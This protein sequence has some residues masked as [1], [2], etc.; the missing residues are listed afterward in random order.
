MLGSIIS[1]IG[2]IAGGIFNANKQEKFAK[3]ALQWKAADAEKAGISKI[4][5]MGAPTHSFSPVNVG[6]DPNLGSSIDKAMGQGGPQSTTTGKMAGASTAITAA[7]LD[8]LRLDNDIKRAELASKLAIAGQPGAGGVLDRDVTSGPTGVQLERKLP[9]SSPIAPHSS[10]GVAPEV[11][12]YR[13]SRGLAPAPPQNLAEVHENNAI[14]RWQWMYRN[15]LL[16]FMGSQH[17]A[18]GP[19]RPGYEWQFNPASGEYIEAPLNPFHREYL[20]YWA[21]KSRQERSR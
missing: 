7:Q 20:R 13:T 2:N 16:P 12:L 1:T 3:S 4:F 10:Y 8:G 5:A 15:Q 17:H 9:P 6:A 11:D 14:M 18:T 19:A 21:G